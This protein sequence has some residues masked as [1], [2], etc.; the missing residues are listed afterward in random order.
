MVDCTSVLNKLC[1]GP[2]APVYVGNVYACEHDF[3]G[4]PVDELRAA[5]QRALEALPNFSV[6]PNPF[7]GG[8][9]GNG[10]AVGGDAGTGADRVGSN[11]NAVVADIGDTAGIISDQ[12]GSVNSGGGAD[13]L[14]PGA[15]PPFKRTRTPTQIAP[16][17]AFVNAVVSAPE[18]GVF[19]RYRTP[20]RKFTDDLTFTFAVGH[21]A[22]GGGAGKVTMR[23][24]SASRIGVSDFGQNY[25]SIRAVL[26]AVAKEAG[27][28][29]RAAR[30]QPY[31]AYHSLCPCSCKCFCCCTVC[32]R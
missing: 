14:A 11:K 1:Y 7:V 20:R 25:R 27:F 4:V 6:K 28:R 22:A 32:S 23:A 3:E 9:A 29:S 30:Y 17:E 10:V 18:L 15:D 21:S 12:P 5:V 31:Y 19:G 26:D 24:M 16:A 8:G 2:C 13:G